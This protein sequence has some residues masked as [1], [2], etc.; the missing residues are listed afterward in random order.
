MTAWP[1]RLPG[2]AYGADYNPE[3]WPRE[4]WA[5]DVRLMREAGVTVATVG[6]FSWALLEPEQGRFELDWLAEVIDLLHEHG[7]AV[8]LATA[9]ASPPPWLTAR[10]PRG[11]PPH[12]PTAPCSRPAAGRPG[13]PAR[14]CS[15]SA[16][17]RW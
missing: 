4:T 1:P 11:A 10:A 2:I 5:E 17:W 8:D 12:A 13:A 16:P 15:A 9:T 3:Q 6:V 7:I 14:R